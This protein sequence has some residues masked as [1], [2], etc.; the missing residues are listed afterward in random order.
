L[1]SFRSVKVGDNT[2]ATE[3]TLRFPW[4]AE[5]V[6]AESIRPER[7]QTVAITLALNAVR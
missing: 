6:P 2:L 5:A 1:L 4:A 3:K 7:S